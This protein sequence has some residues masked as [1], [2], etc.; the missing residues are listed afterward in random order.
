MI[1][2]IFKTVLYARKVTV[3]LRTITYS[4]NFQKKPFELEH[5]P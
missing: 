4:I 5:V 3:E 2:I 1:Q